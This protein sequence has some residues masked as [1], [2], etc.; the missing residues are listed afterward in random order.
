MRQ[1]VDKVRHY[2]IVSSRETDCTSKV[3]K[4]HLFRLGNWV[5]V[6]SIMLFWNIIARQL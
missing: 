1:L 4:S 2:I 3:R 6:A 5:M